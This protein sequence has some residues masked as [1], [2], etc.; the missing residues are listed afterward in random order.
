MFYQKVKLPWVIFDLDFVL[1]L[2]YFITEFFFS[3]NSTKSKTPY[4]L[5]LPAFVNTRDIINLLAT[6]Q[7]SEQGDHQARPLRYGFYGYH[8]HRGYKLH[9]HTPR[10]HIICLVTTQLFCMQFRTER[11]FMVDHSDQ[12]SVYQIIAFN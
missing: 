6:G 5:W 12:W 4:F 10:K 7:L 9:T 8:R 2:A 11:Y 1:K 3:S